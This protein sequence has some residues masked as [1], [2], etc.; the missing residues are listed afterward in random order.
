MR[1]H[2]VMAKFL[3][4]ISHD[5]RQPLHALGLFVAQLRS[6]LSVAERGR[7]IAQIETALAKINHQFNAVLDISRLDAGQLKPDINVFPLATLLLS[8]EDSLAGSAHQKSLKLRIV[9]SSLW[10]RSD[11]VLLDR[12]IVN[13]VSEAMHHA[14]RGKVLLGCRRR[15]AQICIEVWDDGPGQPAEHRA[16]LVGGRDPRA[17][18]GLEGVDSIV[19]EIVR[20]LCGLL[21]HEFAMPSL[22]SRQPRYSVSV[23]RVLPLADRTVPGSH[24]FDASVSKLV[25]VID[26]EPLVRDG[27]IGLL[28]DWGYRVISADNPE[29]AL[30][31][32]ETTTLQPDLIISDFRLEKGQNGIAAIDRMRDAFGRSIPAFLI[33]AD[34]GPELL[35]KAR[36][37]G[38]QL[39]YKP[40]E[41]MTLRALVSHILADG[42]FKRG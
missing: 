27:M 25:A 26:D 16:T 32:L 4:A 39:L 8:A 7:V 10:V 42:M 21:G 30:A 9:P 35:G 36:E 14:A 38:F 3:N 2:D 15:G 33:S 24:E 23:P 22:G 13:L 40:V 28:R 12:I 11:A 34:T 6:P 18:P 31:H 1:Q 41:P 29:A 20:R 37:R 19:P 17:E 5:L